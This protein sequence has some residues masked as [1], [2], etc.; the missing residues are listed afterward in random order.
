MSHSLTQLHQITRFEKTQEGIFGKSN[1]KPKKRV[2][3]LIK[4]VEADFGFQPKK[5]IGD[6]IKQMEEMKLVDQRKNIVE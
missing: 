1:S 3:L 6:L 2:D 4:M 5:D